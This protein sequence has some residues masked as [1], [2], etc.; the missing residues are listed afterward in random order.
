MKMKII[1]YTIHTNSLFKIG[2]FLKI[3]LYFNSFTIYIIKIFR[4]KYGLLNCVYLH[5]IIIINVFFSH[6]LKIK[7][8]NQNLGFV[9]GNKNIII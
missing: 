5:F 8:I 9:C 6:E 2:R 3:T 4:Q 1:A 7:L